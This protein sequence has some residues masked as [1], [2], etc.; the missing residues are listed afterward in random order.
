MLRVDVVESPNTDKGYG[1]TG[2]QPEGHE[3]EAENDW[4]DPIYNWYHAY[5]PHKWK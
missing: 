2:N 5:D 3:R 4:L 1:D